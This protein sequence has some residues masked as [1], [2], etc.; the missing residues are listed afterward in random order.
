MSRVLSPPQ[1]ECR[2]SAPQTLHPATTGTKRRLPPGV[3]T[4][5][6]ICALMRACGRHAHAPLRP[7]L[8]DRIKGRTNPS[9]PL[10]VI[11]LIAMAP[12]ASSVFENE[13]FTL[14]PPR[15]GSLHGTPKRAS[16]LKARR[17]MH[18]Y[19]ACLTSRRWAGQLGKL[20]RLR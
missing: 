16:S 4:D 17:L 2:R 19:T 7:A 14:N 8:C 12:T 15:T 13:T 11:G 6:E 18:P 5:D 1:M 20:S 3:L 9:L 10:N